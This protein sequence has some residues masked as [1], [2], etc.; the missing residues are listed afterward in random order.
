MDRW[1]GSR[2]V[3]MW[4]FGGWAVGWW[5]VSRPVVRWWIGGWAVGQWLGGWP[6]VGQFSVAHGV[7]IIQS[8]C[9]GHFFFLA[10]TWKFP[11]N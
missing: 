7:K 11:G 10:N 9:F 3:V 4:W 6:V 8:V 1:L 5:L 2:P